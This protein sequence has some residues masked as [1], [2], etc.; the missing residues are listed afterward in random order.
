MQNLQPTVSI[1]VPIYKVEKYIQRC[2]ES[3]FSQTYSNLEI[4]F[5]DDCTPDNSITVLQNSLKNFPEREKQT[6][7]IKHEN[8]KGLSAARNTAIRNASGEYILH[9]DSDDYVKSNAIDLFVSKAL[10]T[11]ADIV[12]GNHI[13]DYG[14]EQTPHFERQYTNKQTLLKDILLK[15]H[16][17]NIWNTL[18]KRS[19]YITNN[20]T[21][22]ENIN[23]GED[24]ITISRLLFWA[25]KISFLDEQ[26]YFYNQTNINS[27]KAGLMNR[28]NIK[29]YYPANRFLHD[30]FLKQDQ[31]FTKYLN[32]MLWHIRATLLLRITTLDDLAYERSIRPKMNIYNILFIPKR[33]W[34]PIFLD[35]IKADSLILKL[36]KTYQVKR[37]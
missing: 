17:C 35:L 10:E 25:Q 34:I 28:K 11:N 24:Y 33:F 2:A 12:F 19:L 18:L 9:I 5:I 4:I 22:P 21:T 37:F 23:N 31:Q 29:D 8:N 1:L 16:T 3:I 32:I 36:A 30:F 14:N 26:T 13:T 6:R 27:F 15:K 7:I 20:I